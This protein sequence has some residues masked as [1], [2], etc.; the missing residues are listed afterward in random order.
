MTDLK[1]EEQAVKYANLLENDQVELLADFSN[2]LSETLVAGAKLRNERVE[3]FYMMQA[4]T[5][6]LPKE[7]TDA[8]DAQEKALE[9]GTAVVY[10]EAA[11]LEAGGLSVEQIQKVRSLSGWAK[12]GYMRG[13]AMQGGQDYGTYFTNASTQLEVTVNGDTFTLAEAQ[14]SAQRAAAKAAIA[15]S[16]ISQYRGM[17][18]ELLNKYL[19]E[20]MRDWEAKD[21]LAYAEKQREDFEKL[22]KIE[23]ENDISAAAIAGNGEAF[24]RSINLH[25]DSL[26]GQRIAIRT[27]L[28]KLRDMAKNGQVTRAQVDAIL[29]TQTERFDNGKMDS[30]ANIFAGHIG[31]LNF[32]NA[33]AEAD[34]DRLDRDRIAENVELAE[35]REKVKEQLNRFRDEDGSVPVGFMR[36]VNEEYFRITGKSTPHPLLEGVLN[37]EEANAIAE[38]ELAEQ[39]MEAKGA[40]PFLTVNEY[41]E[42]STPA[43]KL[44]KSKFGQVEIRDN[45]TGLSSKQLDRLKDE[46]RAATATNLK[47]V[48]LTPTTND[49]TTKGLEFSQQLERKF[50]DYYRMALQSGEATN[51]QAYERA[52]EMVK[53]YA[54]PKPDGNY[55]KVLNPETNTLDRVH[56][57]V[58]DS[59]T[60][61]TNATNTKNIP[62]WIR[63]QILKEAD[64]KNPLTQKIDSLA[65]GDMYRGSGVAPLSALREF[66]N[67]GGKGQLPPIFRNLALKSGVEGVTAWDVAA[68]Q[69]ELHY[70]EKLEIPVVEKNVR[71]LPPHVRL[72][73]TQNPSPT[74]TS[75]AG[76]MVGGMPKLAELTGFHEAKAYGGYDAMNI[77]GDGVGRNNVAIGSANSKEKWGIGLSEMTVGEVLR[78]GALHHTHPDFV[79]AAGMYQFIPKTL[80]WV[81]ARE[82]IPMDAPFDKNTQDFLWASQVRWRLSVHSGKE[83]VVFGLRSEWLGL[84]NASSKEILDGVEHFKGSEFNNPQYLHPALLQDKKGGDK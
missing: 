78:R 11:N 18:P 15:E 75:I 13:L 46:L 5:D 26:G 37:D 33:Y 59:R 49:Y 29:A 10:N 28:T 34:Q 42:L 17:S 71:R 67:S 14:G 24:L 63:L 77:G 74:R 84:N 47:G 55:V 1:L 65:G 76:I 48:G 64:G 60:F 3:Q 61:R 12:Y 36:Q 50:F 54:D 83:D 81:V 51:E 40:I 7:Q 31:Y 6:G 21:D 62:H 57:V 27:G 45:E 44:L 23:L 56:Q 22:K 39:Q 8:F 41:A 52:I 16:Y 53:E 32:E 9:D 79:F 66:V 58:N 25:A 2:T 20:P 19:F 69:Y 35:L 43:R 72:F 68:K 4:F 82:G 30:L 70:N 80:R 38:V 73:L